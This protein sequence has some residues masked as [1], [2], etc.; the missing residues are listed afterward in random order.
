MILAISGER[1]VNT[2]FRLVNVVFHAN[3][4]RNP[5][6]PYEK[7]GAKFTMKNGAEFSSFLSGRSPL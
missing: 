4:V 3:S 2:Q 1:F 7:N 5:C 6:W